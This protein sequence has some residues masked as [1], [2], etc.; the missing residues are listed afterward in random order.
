M[1][2]AS[3]GLVSNAPIKL[4][5]VLPFW[6]IL[7]LVGTPC[8]RIGGRHC[9]FGDPA[10][11]PVLFGLSIADS[12]LL[13]D[14]FSSDQSHMRGFRNYVTP[15]QWSDI[16]CLARFSSYAGHSEAFNGSAG[17]LVIVYFRQ[18]SQSTRLVHF[19]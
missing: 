19:F 1:R 9:Q 2:S 7:M 15:L 11:L 3:I 14:R 16:T 12:G 8:C 4:I 18:D 5:L 13:M 6:I 17:A 10:I